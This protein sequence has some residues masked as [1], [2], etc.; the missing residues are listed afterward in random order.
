MVFFITNHTRNAIVSKVSFEG[1]DGQVS[2]TI[3]DSTKGLSGGIM[4]HVTDGDCF[5]VHDVQLKER[6][7]NEK[8]ERCTQST[9]NNKTKKTI[10]Q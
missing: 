6:E 2:I 4:D 3:G 1:G 7:G 5:V 8:G 10:K 9:A